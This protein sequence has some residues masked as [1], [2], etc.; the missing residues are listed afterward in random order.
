MDKTAT[1][2]AGKALQMNVSSKLATTAIQT[3]KA[4]LR[5]K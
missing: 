3:D 1:S 2:S 5:A 4:F